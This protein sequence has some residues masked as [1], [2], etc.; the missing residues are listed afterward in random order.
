MSIVERAGSFLLKRRLDKQIN[1][2]GRLEEKAVGRG[3]FSFEQMDFIAPPQYQTEINSAE[4]EQWDKTALREMEGATDEELDKLFK[5]VSPP[6]LISI[7][8]GWKYNLQIQ[9]N[10]LE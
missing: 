9:R 2:L 7:V 1:R 8:R 4:Q 3:T 6:L 5:I 10:S